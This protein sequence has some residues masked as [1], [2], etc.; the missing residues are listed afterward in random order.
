MCLTVLEIP[1]IYIFCS[2]NLQGLLGFIL[3]LL[4]PLFLDSASLFVFP[5]LFPTQKPTKYLK[6]CH[7]GDGVVLFLLPKNIKPGP[8]S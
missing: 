4:P 2:G 8:V 1:G 7:V 6:G 5:S 3:L